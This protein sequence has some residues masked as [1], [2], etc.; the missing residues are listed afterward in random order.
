MSD[1]QAPAKRGRPSVYSEDIAME[2]CLRIAQGESLRSICAAD[3]MPDHSTVCMWVVD[4]YQGFAN[5]YTRAREVQYL[6]MA[7]ELCDISD[8]GSNDWM[9]RRGAMVVDKEAVDRSKLRVDTRKWL[10]SKM[11]PKVYGDKLQTETTIGFTKEFED[12]IRALNDKRKPKV[13][14]AKPVAGNGCDLGQVAS[15]IRN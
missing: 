13:I 12:F 15:R 11:L 9:E 14:D 8:D 10:L 3:N 7:D 5:R 1:T 4:D 2:I 6:G